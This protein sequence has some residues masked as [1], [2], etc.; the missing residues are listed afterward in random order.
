MLQQMGI[1]PGFPF[2]SKVRTDYFAKGGAMVGIV[3]DSWPLLVP[4][5]IIAID[6][7]LHGASAR[8]IYILQLVQST[9]AGL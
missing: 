6:C 1:K 8:N 4:D 5:L 9:A 7:M 3:P 2:F